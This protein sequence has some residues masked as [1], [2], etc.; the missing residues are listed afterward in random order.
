MT[1]KDGYVLGYR[2]PEL[3]RLHRQADQLAD[4]SAQLF[5]RIGVHP[6]AQVVEIGCGP[7]GCLDLLASRVGI[8]GHVTGVEVSDETAQLARE[9]AATT[10]LGNVMVLSADARDT[11]LQRCA[12][13]FVTARLVLVNVPRPDEIVA[14]AT[15]LARPGAIVA[16]HEV[17]GIGLYCDPPSEAWS[18][19]I[20]LFKTVAAHNGNDWHFGR[21]LPALLR[22]SGLVDV[23]VNS[24]VR[25]YTSDDPRRTLMLDFADNFHDRILAQGLASQDELDA[26]KDALAQHLHDPDTV[27]FDGVY[28][29]AWGRKPADAAA[30]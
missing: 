25:V 7:R 11:G 24:I 22:R 1:G 14:E 2:R 10:G 15:A 18:R 27:V 20:E 12:Y 28:V 23:S 21:R 9:F 8:A 26:L 6:G 19:L 29:Q 17:D 4:D 13:D 5:D 3:D 16:F 30:P